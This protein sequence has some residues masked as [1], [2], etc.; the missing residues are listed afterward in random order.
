[1]VRRLIGG[2]WIIF[3]KLGGGV[4]I[5]FGFHPLFGKLIHF[6]R[7]FFFK[8]VGSTRN[9]A[10][11]PAVSLCG[12]G[13]FPFFLS[14]FP[15]GYLCPFGFHWLHFAVPLGIP[16]VESRLINPGCISIA[17]VGIALWFLQSPGSFNPGWPC[18]LLGRLPNI[19]L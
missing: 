19:T 8:W 13:S 1:M 6:L 2:I 5:F 9:L 15:T 7:F 11:L 17:V 10:Q 18:A 12:P 14:G 3:A 16:L 4:Q